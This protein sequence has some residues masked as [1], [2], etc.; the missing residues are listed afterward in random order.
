MRKH[1]LSA[2]VAASLMTPFHQV[3]PQVGDPESCIPCKDYQ[4]NHVDGLLITNRKN[5]PG[6]PIHSPGTGSCF[7]SHDNYTAA[8]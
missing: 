7:D 5:P 3:R 2:L 6:D 8:T 4:L 1:I